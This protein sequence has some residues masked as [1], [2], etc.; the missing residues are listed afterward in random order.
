MY[1]YRFWITTRNQTPN[2]NYNFSGDTD[3]IKVDVNPTAI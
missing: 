2:L 1:W 3:C